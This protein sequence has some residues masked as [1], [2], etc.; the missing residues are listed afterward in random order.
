MGLKATYNA[1]RTANG[2]AQ[3]IACAIWGVVMA[4]MFAEMVNP[5]I[6]IAWAACSILVI[7]AVVWLPRIYLKLSLIADF[8]IS[9]LVLSEYMTYSPAPTPIYHVNTV[10][11]MQAVSRSA[12][13]HVDVAMWSHSLA[14]ITLCAWSLYLA[15]LVHRQILERKRVLSNEL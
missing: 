9:T 11:G 1:I 12:H 5:Y 15:N 14:I 6:L 2:P 4:G 8:F 13:S 7:T 10:N 3:H